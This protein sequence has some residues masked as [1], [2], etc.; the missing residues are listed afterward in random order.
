MNE[1]LPAPPPMEPKELYN[2]LERFI[3]D[4]QHNHNV[5]YRW[6]AEQ[7]IRLKNLAHDLGING[8]GT[9]R[10]K[11]AVE[12]ADMRLLEIADERN[13]LAKKDSKLEQE[14]TLLKRKS[15]A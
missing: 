1:C 4:N 8:I 9:F 10:T 13:A 3:R 14:A 5:E 6:L 12:L 7:T 2:L 15:A 11:Y